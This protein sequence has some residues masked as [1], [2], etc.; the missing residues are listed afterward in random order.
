MKNTT[1]QIISDQLFDAL[2]E[3]DTD[4]IIVANGDMFSG[5]REQFADTY[6]SNATNQKIKSWCIKNKLIL[7][8]N[9]FKII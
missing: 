4:I 7:K 2:I 1:E 8:I 9:K 5:T 6:F 3:K